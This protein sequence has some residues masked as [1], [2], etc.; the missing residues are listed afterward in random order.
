MAGGSR[1]AIVGPARLPHEIPP[2]ALRAKAV[3]KLVDP[4][5]AG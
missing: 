5:L 3:K 4:G 1:P 2:L